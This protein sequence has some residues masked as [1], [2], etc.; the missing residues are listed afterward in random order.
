MRNNERR[1]KDDCYLE[2]ATISL[3]NM[4]IY[5][6]GLSLLKPELVSWRILFER[7]EA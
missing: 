7:K 1:C 3:K 5:F 2:V 4:T 6:G